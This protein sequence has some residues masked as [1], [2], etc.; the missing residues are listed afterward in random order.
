MNIFYKLIEL[1][2]KDNKSLYYLKDLENLFEI[3]HIKQLAMNFLISIEQLKV[4]FIHSMF[5]YI[6][7][8][9]NTELYPIEYLMNITLNYM[10]DLMSISSNLC[11]LQ[12]AYWA[13]YHQDQLYTW[14]YLHCLYHIK[15][16]TNMNMDPMKLLNIEYYRL[17]LARYA[18]AYCSNHEYLY[19]LNELLGVCMLRVEWITLSIKLSNNNDTTDK[20]DFNI[21]SILKQVEKLLFSNKDKEIKEKKMKKFQ[22][23]QPPFYS[24]FND[25]LFTEFE[26]NKSDSFGLIHHPG[27]NNEE[28]Y[29]W[30]IFLSNW[31]KSSNY[32][33]N[34]NNNTDILCNS[35]DL[36]SNLWSNMVM[37]T[38]CR[39]TR[40]SISYAVI[41][42]KFCQLLSFNQSNYIHQISSMLIPYIE[43]LNN[44]EEFDI[45]TYRIILLIIY[46]YIISI[47]KTNLNEST[48]SCGCY[49]LGKVICLKLYSFIISKEYDGKFNQLKQQLTHLLIIGLKNSLIKYLSIKF[50]MI[51][52]LV[53]FYNDD[54]YR[55]DV[56]YKLCCNHL[57]FGL[58][59]C[60]YYNIP[61]LHGVFYRLKYLLDNEDCINEKIQLEI[62]YLIKWIN[63]S[64]DRLK[65]LLQYSEENIYPFLLKLSSINLLFNILPN[66]CELYLFDGIEIQLHR[67]I[68]KNLL[69]MKKIDIFFNHINYSELLKL[70]HESFYQIEQIHLNN[71]N[72]N[73]NN[74]TPL[75]I[76]DIYAI[77]GLRIFYNLSIYENYINTTDIEDLF[78]QIISEGSV[79]DICRFMNWLDE[80]LYSTYSN[81][82]SINQRRFILE[83]S[84]IFISRMKKNSVNSAWNNVEENL[85][86]YT[87]N[88]EQVLYLI[89]KILFPQG[90]DKT[91]EKHGNEIHFDKNKYSLPKEFY[92]RLITMK[93]NDQ[94]S[95]CEFLKDLITAVINNNNMLNNNDTMSICSIVSKNLEILGHLL[96]PCVKT[97]KIEKEV[98]INIIGDGL[99]SCFSILSSVFQVHFEMFTQ[100]MLL[101]YQRE[102]SSFINIQTQ[103]IYPYLKKFLDLFINDND[104]E[105]SEMMMMMITN[106]PYYFIDLEEFL[107]YFL[108]KPDIRRLFGIDLLKSYINTIDNNW[109]ILK[110]T[111]KLSIF[112]KMINYL[113]KSCIYS[114]ILC[115]YLDEFN[116]FL[117]N[118]HNDPDDD[119]HKFQKCIIKF[120]NQ[121]L[122]L[123]N[124]EKE[125]HM[126]KE[127]IEIFRSVIE[128][129]TLIVMDEKM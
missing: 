19:D 98:W 100:N 65:K 33:N 96:P 116:Q 92:N 1:F 9:H 119:L 114:N 69:K 110:I 99:S 125:F 109:Q 84:E 115:N 16:N 82:L 70:L 42:S 23:L 94:S 88:F 53:Y 39:D 81:R 111:N 104:K 45:I 103:T 41:G 12:C 107:A 93:P 123:S 105:Q 37:E 25:N 24:I 85:K 87:S 47:Y 120:C 67:K 44:Y 31:S 50:P 29:L 8:N 89:N 27:Y 73:N 15:Y 113:K 77:Y 57:V 32:N 46:Y 55:E 11:W 5:N 4:C 17:R 62:D 43:I 40:L 10:N 54:K 121:T 49:P 64:L 79:N 63:K 91:D 78:Q 97:L 13:G 61:E 68:L 22:L 122:T 60:L 106:N 20:G 30:F 36:C 80:L 6:K 26:L 76:G 58:Q 126:I 83:K 86:L 66:D 118:N 2:T 52:D 74:F 129:T 117:F 112:Y 34:N 51:I 127:E 59:L 124:H 128:I 3:N 7:D 108:I 71:N 75:Q 72:N 14:T 28:Y 48:Y 102:T 38:L 35:N 56:I 101:D 90:N 21:S 95:A 18:L